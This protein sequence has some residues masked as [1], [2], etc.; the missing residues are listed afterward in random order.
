[1]KVN[2]AF[3]FPFL[4]TSILTYSTD[5]LHRQDE[6]EQLPWVLYP[7]TLHKR[8]ERLT[9]VNDRTRFGILGN[10]LA[11]CFFVFRNK[12]ERCL[13]HM[14][15]LKSKK[16]IGMDRVKHGFIARDDD[17][18]ERVVISKNKKHSFW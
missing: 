15:S 8:K 17:M 9:Q 18:M 16:V 13:R 1:M 5:S 12:N 14:L 7:E 2:L 11:K 4:M 6:R 3:V 10:N